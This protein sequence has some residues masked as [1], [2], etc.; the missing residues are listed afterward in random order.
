MRLD[1]RDP[2]Y[3]AVRPDG[4]VQFKY[5]SIAVKNLKHIEATNYINLA[6]DEMASF[7]GV[8]S[9]ELVRMAKSNMGQG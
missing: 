4:E 8:T 9:E 1:F 5:R 6:I 2:D 3:M 7:L